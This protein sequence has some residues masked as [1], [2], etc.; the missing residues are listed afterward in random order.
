MGRGSDDE[1]SRSIL[2][3]V[4]VSVGFCIYWMGHGDVGARFQGGGF[5]MSRGLG[6]KVGDEASDVGLE[7]A[8]SQRVR[9]V[10]D[11]DQEPPPH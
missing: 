8:D 7:S 5:G 6:M 9:V 3:P 4:E 10:L 1:A 2:L 11:L